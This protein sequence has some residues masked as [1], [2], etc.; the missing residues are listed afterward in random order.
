MPAKKKTTTKKTAKKTT[1]KTVKKAAKKTVKK[2]AKKTVKKAAKKKSPPLSHHLDAEL[3]FVKV[4]SL[5]A[6][7]GYN[8][9][10][11]GSR[12]G[13]IVSID[14]ESGEV[15]SEFKGHDAFVSALGYNP[16]GRVLAS[17]GNDK[18][19]RLW[20][21]A[22]GT[23][24]SDLAGIVASPRARTLAGQFMRGARPGHSLTALA[25]AWGGEEVIGTGGQ[26]RMVKYWEEGK[27]LRTFDWH[28]GP[29]S[30]VAFRP[31]SPRLE[32]LSASHDGSLRS[33]DHEAGSMIHKYTGHQGAV[34]DAAWLDA[35]RIVSGDLTGELLIWDANKESIMTRM[36]R[37]SSGVR[38]LAVD[39]KRGRVYAGLDSGDLVV[40]DLSG[41]VIQTIDAHSQP[42]R[43]LALASNGETLVSGGNG[44]R[45]RLWRVS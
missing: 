26:D 5:A 3:G 39:S 11:V 37:A 42:I 10:A 43:A 28:E 8:E 7:P 36:R 25:L 2:A 30:A 15:L 35:D 32:L 16:E 1:K 18:T 40:Y 44:G 6:R 31:G 23:F 34:S 33:W 4:L 20:N 29:I 19:L 9:V 24:D 13:L 45:V 41:E 21:A 22:N 38:A 12:S 27:M 17:T 14:L